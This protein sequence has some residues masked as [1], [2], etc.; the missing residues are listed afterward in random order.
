MTVSVTAFDYNGN[1]QTMVNSSGTTTYTWD[2]EN[3]LFSTAL[4]GS[5]GTVYS[6]MIPSAEESTI[7]VE[8]Y[9]YLRL[10]RRQP[11]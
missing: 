7:L 8:W 3:R 2:Y 6:N 1:T 11:D 4:P 9:E 5:G 10:R